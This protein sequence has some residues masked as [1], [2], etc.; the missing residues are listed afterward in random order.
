MLGEKK[1]NKTLKKNNKKLFIKFQN[2]HLSDLRSRLLEDLQNEHF[3][4][5][6]GKK[7]IIENLTIIKVI[8][9]KFPSKNDYLDKSLTHL[10]LNKSIFLE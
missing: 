9:L 5:L 10:R 3:A 1:K 6:L 4:I 2:T 7:E 8:D